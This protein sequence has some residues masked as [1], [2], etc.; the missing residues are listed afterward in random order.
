MISGLNSESM[1]VSKK[2]PLEK[3]QGERA[4]LLRLSYVF[5]LLIILENT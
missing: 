2:G 5:N 3:N 1:M 4:I